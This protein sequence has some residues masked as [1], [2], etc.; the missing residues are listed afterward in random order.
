[1]HAQR[2]DIRF[3][4]V[5]DGPMRQEIETLIYNHR[6]EGIV[7]IAGLWPNPWE[8]YPALDLL[9]QTSRVEGMPFTLLEAMA[10][11]VPVVAMGVGG[12]PE[13][14]DVHLSGLLA[15]PGDF[16]GAGDAA[17][18]IL[19]N[20]DL[21]GRMGR[22]AR[23]RVENG[24]SLSN[25]VRRMTGLWRRL[26]TQASKET[27][28]VWAVGDIDSTGVASPVAGDATPSSPGLQAAPAI[29]S[30]LPSPGKEAV[31]AAIPQAKLPPAPTK[32]P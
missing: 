6:L 29:L 8:I 2:P 23:Q 16:N 21:A 18:Q 4:L 30:D 20:P 25:T 15:A 5:G 14:L 26:V 31:P 27:A 17:L 10:C 11:A 12:V 7:H 24:Y 28:A 19:N 32:E 22:H 3:V 13:I 1:M 9:V